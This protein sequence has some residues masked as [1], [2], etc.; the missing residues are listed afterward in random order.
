MDL[1]NRGHVYRFLLKPV[2]PGR[3]R[4][5]IEASVKHHMEAPDSAFKGKPR[6]AAPVAKAPPTAKAP[7]ATKPAPAARPAAQQPAPA[8]ARPPANPT[9]QPAAKPAAPAAKKPAP[10][11]APKAPPRPAPAPAAKAAPKKT[12]RANDRPR[13]ACC[14]AGCQ[15]DR[16][17]YFGDTGARTCRGRQEGA[18]ICSNGRLTTIGQP[19]RR[20]RGNEQF[21][22]DDDRYRYF[23]RQITVGSC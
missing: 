1:I 11:P 17:A 21:H 12:S 15:E 14:R 4:L 13:A 16:T 10:K 20:F 5:A 23:G 8:A 3:S 6:A 19:G 18:R 22:R 2:S 7:P 9:P